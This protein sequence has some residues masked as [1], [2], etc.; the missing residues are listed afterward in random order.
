MDL[1]LFALSA[2]ACLATSAAIADPYAAYRGTTITVSWPTLGHFQLAETVLDEFEQ[3]TGIN[4]EVEAIP[5]LG[6]RDRQMTELSRDVGEFDLVSW[7]IMWKGEYVSNGL[8]SPL[9]PFFDNAEL[10]DPDYDVEEIA[11]AYLVSGGLVGGEKGYLQGPG[12]KLYGVPYGAETSMMA[13]RKDIFEDLGI[14]VPQTYTELSQAIERLHDAGIPALTS[15][16]AGGNDVT[17]A[18][19][20]HLGPLGGEIFDDNWE[21]QINSPEAIEAATFLRRVFETGPAGMDR[22]NFGQSTFEF[23]SG[24]AA[25]YLDNIKVASAVKDRNLTGLQEQIAFAPHPRGR[26]C[27]A[28]T[29]GFS[30]GIPAN[31]QN[32]EA[33]FLLLQYLTSK[34]GDQRMVDLGSDPIRVSTMI[35]NLTEQPEYNAVIGSL[36]C[37]DTDWRPLIPEWNAIQND[38]L[39]PA[40]LEVTRTDESVAAIMDRAN[41]QL[42]SLM[43]EAGYY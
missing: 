1:K 38:V 9:Q 29:G 31:S 27:S 39:G 11:G 37:A 24:G 18:W 32:K 8:L 28:E 21:P 26:E 35:N 10:A 16:G 42:K 20:L 7:V 25:M 41:Q 40:L 22:F 23:L 5:Y 3:E 2:V 14:G 34:S 36:A 6:L 43:T 19:L 13:Y 17:F 15:R 33:A 12:A 30:I 4:V